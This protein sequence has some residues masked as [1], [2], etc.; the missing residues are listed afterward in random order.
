MKVAFFASD[1]IA[2]ESIKVL[3][4]SSICE[5]ACVVSNPDREKGRGKK[6]SPNDVSAFALDN[7]IKLF[8]PNKNE[9][10]LLVEDF[11]ALGIDVIFVMAYG[12]IL[13]DGILNYG[14]YCLNLHGSILPEFR[15]ASPVECAI[16]TG[17]AKTGVCLMKIGKRM[18]A[19]D[20][21]DC[22]EISIEDSDTAQSLREKIGILASEVLAENLEKISNQQLQFTPQDE[23]K[24]TYVRKL[25]KGDLYLDFNK[26]ARE[27][28]NRI[29]GFSS[30]IFTYENLDIKVLK[31]SFEPLN[32]SMQV[33][34][35]L[36]DGSS[37]KIACKD[38]LLNIL[39]LQKPCAKSMSIK[40]FLKGFVFKNGDILA[41]AKN[42]EVLRF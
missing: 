4:H 14:N 9:E 30:G 22:K 36:C 33:G 18:D 39:E 13:R 29:R 7:D 37:L 23:A 8:R 17:K 6:L 3:M 20:V 41:S 2:I 10:D 26:T 38:S 21:A 24:A 15:G 32:K 5:L 31:T 40:D 16:A 11:Y 34:E 12:S 27:L 35:I 42:E 25:N 1:K 19:G 28:F